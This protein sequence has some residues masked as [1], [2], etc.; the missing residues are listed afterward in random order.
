MYNDGVKR[1]IHI[2]EENINLNCS[3]LNERKKDEEKQT[4]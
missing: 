4:E 2:L 1:F 3:L